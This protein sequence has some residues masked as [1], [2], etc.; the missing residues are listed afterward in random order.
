MQSTRP[1]LKPADAPSVTLWLTSQKNPKIIAV[2]NFKGGIGKTTLT[3]P[4]G[5]VACTDRKARPHGGRRCTDKPDFVLH[6]TYMP[7]VTR[8]DHDDEPPPIQ[9][10]PGGQA[11]FDQVD[12]VSKKAE[13]LWHPVTK[14]S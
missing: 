1:Q 11:C 9:L 14:F 12:R 7:P 6:A 3:T 8:G 13:T 2:Y 5:A 10:A 4:V